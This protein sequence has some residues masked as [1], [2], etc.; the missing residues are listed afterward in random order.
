MKPMEGDADAHSLAFAYSL[1][2]VV[3]VCRLLYCYTTL[4]YLTSD[5]DLLHTSI[6][7]STLTAVVRG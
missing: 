7:T 3:R 4:Y 2:H 1:D 5:P 6:R